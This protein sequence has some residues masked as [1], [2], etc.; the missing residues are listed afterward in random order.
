MLHFC[1]TYKGAISVFL[2]LILLPVFLLAGVII[3]GSRLYA[4]RNIVSGAGDLAMNAALAD[5]D[6]ILKD[7]YGLFAMAGEEVSDDTVRKYFSENINAQ[8][9]DRGGSYGRLDRKSVV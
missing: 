9:L 7:M 8:N 6:P 2:S 4:C 1:Q 5:Y 3:D